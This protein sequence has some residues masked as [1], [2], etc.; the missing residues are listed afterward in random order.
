MRRS[1]GLLN[2]CSLK[3]TGY[4]NGH[5]KRAKRADPLINPVLQSLIGEQKQGKETNEASEIKQ[6]CLIS[7]DSVQMTSFIVFCWGK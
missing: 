7:G 4:Q 6:T 1:K 2:L 5:S 3:K